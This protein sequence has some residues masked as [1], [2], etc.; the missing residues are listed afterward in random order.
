[1]SSSPHCHVVGCGEYDNEG[2][3]QRTVS[4]TVVPL[5]RHHQVCKDEGEGNN[6]GEDIALLSC[7]C[8]I[9]VSPLLCHWVTWVRKD[10]ED[11][12]TMA[13]AR[14]HEG[15]GARGQ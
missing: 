10:G 2:D 4:S 12:L 11:K 14:A 9:L 6:E 1:M 7:R 15:N 5:A 13:R 8:P 3:A